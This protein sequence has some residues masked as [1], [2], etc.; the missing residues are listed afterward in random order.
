MPQLT[1][2]VL[3]DRQ[4]TPVSHTFTPSDKK[5]NVGILVNNTGTPIGNER[6]GISLSNT[7]SRYKAVLKL[8]CPVVVS[9]IINGVTVP[10]VSRTSYAEVHFSF[11]PTSTLQERKDVVGMIYSA[12][13]S[14]QTMLNKV[15]T[16]L[17]S[18]Y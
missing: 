13:G 9:E 16:E 8:S 6:L 18:V 11:P 5:G 10:T 14:S 2:V 15:F 7:N 17:E 12:L 1:P 3:T 4:A